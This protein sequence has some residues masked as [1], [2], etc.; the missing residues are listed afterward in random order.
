[1]T[2]KVKEAELMWS[3]SKGKGKVMVIEEMREEVDCKEGSH[4]GDD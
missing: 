2:P 3:R 1:V 4:P